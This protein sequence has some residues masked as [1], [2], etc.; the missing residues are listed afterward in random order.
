M[1]KIY[2]TPSLQVF[3]DVEAI[4]KASSPKRTTLDM[5]FTSGTDYGD[6]T[7]SGP[8]RDDC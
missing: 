7:F 1:K 3:G 8:Y 2:S 6:L 5:T 4:T